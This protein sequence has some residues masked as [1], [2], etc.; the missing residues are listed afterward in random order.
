LLRVQSA[1]ASSCRTDEVGAEDLPQIVGR[2]IYQTASGREIL[3]TPLITSDIIQTTLAPYI[4][5]KEVAQFEKAIKQP[6]RTDI[7][8]FEAL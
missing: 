5:K 6:R 1:T 7:V 3:Q 2:A 4:V 8:T